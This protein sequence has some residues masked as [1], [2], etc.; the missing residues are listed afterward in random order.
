MRGATGDMS[1]YLIEANLKAK[2]TFWVG[3]KEEEGMRSGGDEKR[4]R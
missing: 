3:R 4:R 2:T 1:D